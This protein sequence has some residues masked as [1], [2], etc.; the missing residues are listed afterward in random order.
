MST[1]PIL[2]LKYSCFL[3]AWL[4]SCNFFYYSDAAV[5]VSF[6]VPNIITLHPQAEW[7]KE[8]D[9]G[10]RKTQGVWG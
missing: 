10:G 1:F 5:T 8:T 6:S 4:H 2:S 9:L 7:G 3:G